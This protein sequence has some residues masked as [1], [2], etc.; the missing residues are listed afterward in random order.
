MARKSKR[1][2]KRSSPAVKYAAERAA[3]R[4]AG[5]DPE[6]VP[7]P[8]P[9]PMRKGSKPPPSAAPAPAPTPPPIREEGEESGM[10]R[11]TE[12]SP[13]FCDI[14][15]DACA[16]GATLYELA[17]LLGVTRM[18][19]HRWRLQ[20]KEFCDA[21][22]IGKSFADQRVEESLYE[23]AVGYS[24]NSVKIMQNEGT[25]VIVPYVAH[26]PPDVAAIKHWLANRQPKKWRADPAD[27][28]G[29]LGAAFLGALKAITPPPGDVGSESPPDLLPPGFKPRDQST[30]AEVVE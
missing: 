6:A 1:P 17:E 5:R 25:P 27:V 20:H 12:Y 2:P 26:V 30:D 9:P 21:I 15:A 29:D 24:Y 18:T 4:S 8:G 14:A 22:S 3:A 19:I 16:R 7:L 23:R 10:G 11:P 13:D 28:V